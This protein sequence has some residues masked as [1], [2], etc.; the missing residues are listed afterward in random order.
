MNECVLSEF[1]NNELKF[2]Q[3]SFGQIY[4]NG[5][6]SISEDEALYMTS[7]RKIIFNKN[8][9][10]T[11]DLL[12]D[13]IIDIVLNGNLNLVNKFPNMLK[14][15]EIKGKTNLE[16]IKNLKYTQLKKLN[17]IILNPYQ[18]L[19]PIL[20]LNFLP[21][22]IEEISLSIGCKKIIFG[23]STT[24]LKKFEITCNNKLSGNDLPNKLTIFNI[25]YA[26]SINKL[27]L[28]SSIEMMEIKCN[29]KKFNFPNS[30]KKLKITSNYCK[31]I[32]YNLKNMEL[33]LFKNYKFTLKTNLKELVLKNSEKNINLIVKKNSLLKIFIDAC[34]VNI[35]NYNNTNNN[36]INEIDVLCRN[37][38]I[39]NNILCDKLTI[40]YKNINNVNYSNDELLFNNLNDGIN[41]ISIYNPNYLKS[42]VNKIT[43]LPLLLNE[44]HY[45][46]S[47]KDM[48][49]SIYDYFEKLK[50]CRQYF[51]DNNDIINNLINSFQ[52]NDDIIQ[53]NSNCNILSKLFINS[54]NN[55]TKLINNCIVEID[56]DIV[57]NNKNN[58][59]ITFLDVYECYSK[60]RK[61]KKL[62]DIDK[63][64]NIIDKINKLKE[65]KNIKNNKLTILIFFIINNNYIGIKEYNVVE[66]LKNI[67]CTF[68]DALNIYCKLEII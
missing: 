9:C 33:N 45:K 66:K 8:Y 12:P 7:V 34:N 39:A 52:I 15:L 24:N 37:L 43:K 48:D 19:N 46:S 13:N 17:A 28:T 14:Y 4:Y 51:K 29:D 3:I 32:C 63:F 36:T 10:G 47:N 50:F 44:L 65:I 31:K 49:D 67:G 53:I 38:F 30:I 18:N 21:S 26:T 1:I 54:I 61:G 58:F 11:I 25:L 2:E 62:F 40:Y 60:G 20:N 68:D 56:N 57:K 41:V 59:I 64:T 22:T 35:I 16:F 6:F 55:N 5:E 42:Y 27:Y 23:N